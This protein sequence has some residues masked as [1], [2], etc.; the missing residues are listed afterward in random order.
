MKLPLQVLQGAGAA[1]RP[2]RA[3]ASWLQR[4]AGQLPAAVISC[5]RAC[6]EPAKLNVVGLHSWEVEEA[7]SSLDRWLDE[8]RLVGRWADAPTPVQVG[9]IFSECA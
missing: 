4:L 7:G 8:R 2:G 5:R 9:E 6:A 1:G 3:E